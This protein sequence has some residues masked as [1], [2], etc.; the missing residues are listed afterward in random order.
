MYVDFG[1]HAVACA[2]H[3]SAPR[4]DFNTK[5]QKHLPLLLREH[6]MGG[7]PV[8]WRPLT[9]VAPFGFEDDADV[10]FF[11]APFAFIGVFFAPFAPFRFLFLLLPSAAAPSSNALA[12]F[13]ISLVSLR[14]PLFF[15]FV[16]P[17]SS[18]ATSNDLGPVLVSVFVSAGLGAG[19]ADDA[20][21]F[22]KY[23]QSVPIGIAAATC[24]R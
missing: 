24:T 6:K 1:F 11:F 9:A 17:A 2:Q 23:V 22:A 7:P 14:C 18:A 4:C 19:L 3:S 16:G 5:Q 12:A 8:L 10:F 13:A 20:F 15:G 21:G